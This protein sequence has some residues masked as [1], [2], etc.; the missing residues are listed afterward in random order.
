MKRN[1]EILQ[2]ATDLD[3]R[4]FRIV[5]VPMPRTLQRA[6]VLSAQ[7]DTHFSEQWRADDFA[8][9]EQ[10]D[11]GDTV[12]QVAPV[13]YLNYVA[14]NGVVLVPDYASHGTPAVTQNKVRTLFERSFPGRRIVFVDSVAANW[15]AG[16]PHCATLSQ[17]AR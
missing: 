1:L 15:Y 10:R 4:P 3:G 9:V 14:A 17:P 8:P 2:R 16:G 11:D 7:A 13:S 12:M 6:V 5:K